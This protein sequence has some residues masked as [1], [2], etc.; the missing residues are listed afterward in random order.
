MQTKRG[1]TTRKRPN[2][3]SSGHIAGKEG[4]GGEINLPYGCIGRVLQGCGRAAWD[5][6]APSNSCSHVVGRRLASRSA[7]CQHHWCRGLEAGSPCGHSRLPAAADG[8]PRWRWR[9][10]RR[11][12]VL[13]VGC[14]E[15]SLSSAALHHME[16][17]GS[18][19]RLRVHC[20]VH[21]R[22]SGATFRWVGS[23]RRG[24]EVRPFCGHSAHFCP[25]LN[26]L[27]LTRSTFCA[28]EAPRAP[29]SPTDILQYHRTAS[30]VRITTVS[31]EVRNPKSREHVEQEDCHPSR[32]VGPLCPLRAGHSVGRL[33]GTAPLCP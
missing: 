17:R 6:R 31:A 18:S 30:H 14:R 4:S 25:E 7:T 22:E 26:S 9:G 1:T 15:G 19:C 11:E 27:Q 2:Q 10:S 3:S 21:V 23:S 16:G 20:R 8:N 13:D 33:F 29:P 5:G 24:Q 32:G 12:Q 28:R